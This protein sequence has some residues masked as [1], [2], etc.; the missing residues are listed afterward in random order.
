MIDLV[1]FPFVYPLCI[2]SFCLWILLFIIR[3][4]YDK[5]ITNNFDKSVK[6]IQHL[7]MINDFT[8]KELSL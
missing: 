2:Y 4:H 8:K 1:N 5:I 6:I 3:P 7:I